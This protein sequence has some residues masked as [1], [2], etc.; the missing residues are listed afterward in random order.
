MLINC[1]IVKSKVNNYLSGDISKKE[2]SVWAYKAKHTLLTYENV[3]ELSNAP[4]QEII[5]P[6]TQVDGLD[7]CKHEDIVRILNILDGRE[8]VFYTYHLMIKSEFQEEAIQRVREHFKKYK[9]RS[10]LSTTEIEEIRVFVEKERQNPRSIIDLLSFQIAALLST[11]YFFRPVDEELLFGFHS[12][13]YVQQ[14]DEREDRYLDKLLHLLDCAC[15]FEP[16]CVFINYHKGV[17][18][19]SLF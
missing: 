3:Y 15:G 5:I 2:L 18:D 17:P 4:L 8:D 11:G 19:I 12:A 9:E 6:L 13:V 10:H 16:V 14:E 1:S 7:P